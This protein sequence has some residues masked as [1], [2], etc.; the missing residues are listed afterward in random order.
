MDLQSLIFG[1]FGGL[2]L[3]IFGIKIMGD[4]LK[5]VTGEKMRQIL[6]HLTG[7]RFVG[8]FVG[9]IVTSL[10]QS[11]SA[12]TVLVV[13]FVNAGLMTLIQAIPVILGANIGT[14]I[15]AQLVAFKLTDYALPIVGTG[16]FLFIFARSKRNREIGES[17]LGFG[18]LFLGLSI[19]GSA[20]KMLGSG[21]AIHD[22]FAMFSY[23]PLLGVII[24]MLA[25]AI[26]QSSSVT[27][28][29]IVV[30]AS[31]G[32][33][34][35]GA[36]IPLILGTNIGT[37]VTAVLASIKT[38]LAARRAAMAHVFFNLI[39][40]IVAFV[41]LPVYTNIAINSSIIL[42][43]Q[44][45]NV[46]TLFNVVNALLFIGFVP[47]YAKFIKKIVPGEEIAIEK[48]PQ[49]ID[50][51]LLGTPPIA[52]DASRK[53]IM[54]M[55]EFANEMVEK[56]MVAFYGG[57]R[58]NI[59][60][61]RIREETVDELRD[62]IAD[63]LVKIT[64]REITDKE[65]RMIPGLLHSIN[66]I[67][68]IGDHA[69]NIADLAERRIDKKVDLSKTA[70]GEL[71][72]MHIIVKDMISMTIK[73]LAELNK[74]LTKNI[75]VKEQELNELFVKFRESHVKRLSKRECNN[76]AGLVFIDMLSNFEK[77]G[78]HLT[79]IAQAIEG[80]LQW[81]SDDIY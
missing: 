7:N 8:L 40:T 63:Y 43:R 65:A 17:I 37:S 34:D 38:N 23:N 72:K 4:G 55:I 14:T 66:D 48:G 74:E 75:L 52:I 21:S 47:L 69:E 58:S 28:G 46:H 20:V 73:S 62:S 27:T 77:I 9:T 11:S 1:I 78:D 6:K 61:V 60:T 39:G 67:E 25:T 64:E 54:R 33:L 59:E 80:K 79:N 76:M 29:I 26:V 3:F 32:L 2:G 5:K 35:L 36:A 22:V 70:M 15:T 57:D 56:S 12:T 49:Y 13:G 50:K 51:N 53:E 19:M 31:M 81:N 71:E 16:T 41:L 68:R 30:M 44:I 18:M 24:G 42:E 45:A 10:I